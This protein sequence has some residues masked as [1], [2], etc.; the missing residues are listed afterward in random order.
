MSD[1]NVGSVIKFVY[2]D[3]ESNWFGLTEAIGCIERCIKSS[4]RVRDKAPFQLAFGPYY[5][6]SMPY[7]NCGCEDALDKGN[8]VHFRVVT[9]T[10]DVFIT[11]C[12][13]P[14]GLVPVNAV[15][16]VDSVEQVSTVKHKCSE[17]WMSVYRYGCR[18][19]GV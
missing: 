7:K 8:T 18:C 11:T 6:K 5:E 2:A 17:P 10:G 19:G 16:M 13:F 9:S 4:T 3:Y 15:A 12:A 14:S 1:I